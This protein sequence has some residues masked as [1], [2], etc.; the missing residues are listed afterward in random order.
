MLA[1][2]S[3]IDKR[4]AVVLIDDQGQVQEDLGSPTL[5]VLAP[6]TVS[7]TCGYSTYYLG[8][9]V[10]LPYADGSI[11]RDAHFVWGDGW[12]RHLRTEEQKRIL[13]TGLPFEEF[14]AT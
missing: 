12:W 13:T 10:R 9:A 7:S 8:V 5:I 6:S 11:S 4:V 14:A 2:Q 1:R 3:S